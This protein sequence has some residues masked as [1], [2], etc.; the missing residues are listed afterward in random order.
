LYLQAEYQQLSASD[1][2]N[3]FIENK[4]Y[5]HYINGAFSK[6][7]LIF[8]P[9]NKNQELEDCLLL[10]KFLKKYRKNVVF[11]MQPVHPK[12]YSTTINNFLPIKNIID[13]SIN[14]AGIAYLDMYTNDFST[15]KPG[16]LVDIMH[17]GPRGWLEINRFI[18]EQLFKNSNEKI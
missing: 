8:Q 2:N 18:V 12:I 7:K 13:K 4:Y 11:V 1:S 10:I 17:L 9:P 14:E 3:L 6:F 5:R 15:F 16:T